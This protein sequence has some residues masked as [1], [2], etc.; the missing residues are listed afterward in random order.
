MRWTLSTGTVLSLVTAWGMV[1]HDVIIILPIPSFAQRTPQSRCS[2]VVLGPICGSAA[3]LKK[4][5]WS[6]FPMSIDYRLL[7]QAFKIC[8]CDVTLINSR[9]S[10][11][12]CASLLAGVIE[13]TIATHS[14]PKQKHITYCIRH[15]SYMECRRVSTSCS[16]SAIY[17]YSSK[18]L[19]LDVSYNNE[20]SYFFVMK[21]KTNG[22][23]QL[24]IMITIYINNPF[25]LNPA[26]SR[27]TFQ[28]FVTRPP[29]CGHSASQTHNSR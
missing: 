7:R 5:K 16:L 26:S 20:L 29:I 18:Q 23:N 21:R 11:T 1:Y 2:L 4:G 22:A 27:K 15:H 12:I 17:R 6:F 13:Q 28:C 9:E 8:F 14:R 24:K 25:V 10:V 3:P 19:S